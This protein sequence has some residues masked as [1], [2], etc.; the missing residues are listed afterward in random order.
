LRDLS[1]DVEEIGEVRGLGLLIGVE[2]V[3]DRE[4][5]K[6]FAELA[7]Q[8]VR[9]ATGRGVLIEALGPYKNVLRISP[10]LNINSEDLMHSVDVIEQLL[11]DLS[12]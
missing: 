8:V 7:K 3:E 4:S 5:K 11:T 9:A 12:R 2:L 6:P 1:D 10:P